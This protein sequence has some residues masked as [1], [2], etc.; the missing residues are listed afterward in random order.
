MDVT[1]LGAP[2]S[3]QALVASRLDALPPA[4]RHVLAS[5]SILG[6][7]LPRTGLQAL[8]RDP[9]LDTH[10]AG[11]VRREL[12]TIQSDRFAADHGQLKFVQTVVRQVAYDTLS[13]R[14]RRAGHLA[15]ARH[16]QAEQNAEELSAL[17]AQHLLDAVTHSSPADLDTAGLTEQAVELLQTAATRASSLGAAH[18][19]LRHLTT[20]LGH[21]S[22]PGTQLALHEAAAV[23]AHTAGDYPTCLIHAASVLTALGQS[24]PLRA[25]HTV[26]VAGHVLI[27]TS[28]PA[29]ACR[30]LQKAVADLDSLPPVTDAT[31][32]DEATLVLL[33][34]LG[35]GLSAAGRNAEWAPVSDRMLGLAERVGQPLH[36][37]DALIST[38]LLH[39][40]SGR[41][42]SGLL[43]L[44]GAAELART[45]QLPVQ[46]T[47]ALVNLCCFQRSRDLPAGLVAG[48]EAMTVAERAP[49]SYRSAGQSNLA[50]SLHLAGSWA[51]ADPLLRRVVEVV[52]PLDSVRSVVLVLGLWQQQAT[53]GDAAIEAVPDV[54]PDDVQARSWQQQAVLMLAHQVG[55]LPAA[56]A[57]GVAS[58]EAAQQLS[59]LD[60]DFPL[61][62]PPA[63]FASLKAGLLEQAE[64]QIRLVADAPSGLLNPLLCAQLPR[65]E[66]MLLAARRGNPE[67]LLRQAIEGLQAFGAVPDCART[68]HALAD[69]LASQGRRAEAQPLHAAARDTYAALGAQD[70]ID[71]LDRESLTLWA[72]A[73]R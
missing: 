70:W 47:R 49:A 59:G 20:A 46:L 62:W 68:Q 38:G 32:A 16:L 4:E 19:A 65:L 6:L 28:Q 27:S 24:D 51:E 41:P 30:L 43:T 39:L 35:R 37:T 3:L 8:V 56:A 73:G 36:L 33:S 11:L 26:A 66:G 58:L 50:I 60:D 61:L 55:D 69:W 1:A 54:A 13:R 23:A 9:H 7:A 72:D 5:A 12:L 15:A 42:V 31:T 34:A 22:D 21:A 40:G 63:V 14:D 18:E 25:A 10:L 48:R 71:Q 67:L 2:A 44:R 57:A 64:Q 53:A 29:E 17:T 45:A 52:Q